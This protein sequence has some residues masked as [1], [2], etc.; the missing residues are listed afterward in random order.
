MSS[1]RTFGDAS[2][3]V[4]FTEWSD[5][6]GTGEARAAEVTT[7]T[8]RA[9]ALEREAEAMAKLCQLAA[10]LDTEGGEHKCGDFSSRGQNLFSFWSILFCCSF[11][12]LY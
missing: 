9:P 2:L 1:T 4:D 3:G 5:W 12:V 6:L 7:V 11:S 10:R 8:R